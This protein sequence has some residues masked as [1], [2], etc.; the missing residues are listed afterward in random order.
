MAIKIIKEKCKGCGICEKQCPF[1]AIHIVNG[2]AEVNEKCTICG[3]CIEAC[4]F[5]A[6]KKEEKKVFKKDIS[7]YKG[8]LVYAE[9]RQGEITPVVIELL[10][11]GKKLANEIGTDLSA[12]LLGNNVGNLA[13]KL[14]KYGADK[15]YIAD[16]KKLKNYTTDGYAT[17]ISNAIYK[18][19]PESVL[20]GATHIGRDL[21][22]RIAARVDTGLTADCTKLEI[23]PEDKKIKQT[24]PAFGG[25]LMATIVCKNHR[26]QMSPK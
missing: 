12:I 5:D 10:G 18:Y 16:N 22:P 25:N 6:I 23:D 7:S 11:E 26:P 3:A 14:I 9:Q 2:V 13:E 17:V 4:P 19:K 21:A 24:R 1:D 20:F 8:V 15:V